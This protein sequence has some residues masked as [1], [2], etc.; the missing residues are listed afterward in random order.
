MRTFKDIT[1]QKMTKEQFLDMEDIEDN[2]ISFYSD[3]EEKKEI[4]LLK[5]YKV[6]ESRHFQIA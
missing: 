5:A 4:Y 6:W 2:T 3:N 1:F